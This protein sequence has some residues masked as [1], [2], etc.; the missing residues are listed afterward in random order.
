MKFMKH[1]I[2]MKHTIA[3]TMTLLAAGAAWAADTAPTNQV[4]DAISQTEGRH[5][6]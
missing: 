3:L 2:I 5:Q 4:A 1:T 6:L